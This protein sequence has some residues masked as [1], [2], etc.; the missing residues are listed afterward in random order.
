MIE[1]A[2]L[3]AEEMSIVTRRDLPSGVRSR[4]LDQPD[5]A[6]DLPIVTAY[7]VRRPR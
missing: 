5:M 3:R 2:G 7:S 6:A 1:A 4:K